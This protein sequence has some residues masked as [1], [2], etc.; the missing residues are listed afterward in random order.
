MNFTA[1]SWLDFWIYAVPFAYRSGRWRWYVAPGVEEG[2][3]GTESL[4]RFGAEYA[5]EVGAIEIA[6]QVAVDFV[7]GEDVLVLGVVFLKGF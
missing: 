5:F 7:G 6:P 2:D 1:T 3:Q 4:L